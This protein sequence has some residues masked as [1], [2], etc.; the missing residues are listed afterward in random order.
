MGAWQPPDAPQ[1]L[2]PVFSIPLSQES[3]LNP[4]GM[5]PWESISRDLF[6]ETL[7]CMMYKLTPMIPPWWIL[8]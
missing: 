8:H 1:V 3:I 5:R 4:V 7:I 6:L 2:L